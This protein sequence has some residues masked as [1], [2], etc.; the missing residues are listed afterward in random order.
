M[1]F[2]FFYPFLNIFHNKQPLLHLPGTVCC[3]NKAFLYPK[4]LKN[5]M[6]ASADMRTLFYHVS[7]APGGP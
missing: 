3:Y 4:A 6:F 2:N 5:I 7:A 1:L